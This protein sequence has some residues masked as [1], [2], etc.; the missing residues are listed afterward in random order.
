MLRLLNKITNDFDIN[1]LL[2]S[3]FEN[4]FNNRKNILKF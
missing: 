4:S 1:L 3:T 2:F